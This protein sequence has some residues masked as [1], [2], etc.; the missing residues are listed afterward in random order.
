MGQSCWVDDVV[1]GDD[2]VVAAIVV[3]VIV[4]AAIVVAD[5]IVV[6]DDVV[7]AS[8]AGSDASTSFKGSGDE[9][10]LIE[11]LEWK[12]ASWRARCCSQC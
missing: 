3:D 5:A 12:N 9:R 8:V 11:V 4:V 7:A 1:V 10:L 2:E 6:E